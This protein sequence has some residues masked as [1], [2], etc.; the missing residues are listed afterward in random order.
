MV[1]S[2]ERAISGLKSEKQSAAQSPTLGNGLD[3]LLF[4]RERQNDRQ[5][6]YDVMRS[7]DGGALYKGG[8]QAS[9]EEGAAGGVGKSDFLP[10][11]PP[12]SLQPSTLRFPFMDSSDRER[13]I[14]NRLKA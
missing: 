7:S 13:E 14:L 4:H 10:K 5:V 2:V 11:F 1:V 12:V 6:Q 9:D 3:Y 8:E